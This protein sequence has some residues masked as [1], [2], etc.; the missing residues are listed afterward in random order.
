M[1]VYSINGTELSNV[2]G[3]NGAGL[4]EAFSIDDTKVFPDEP[5]VPTPR[6][7]LETAILSSMPSISVSGIKQGA[8]T[9]GTYIY[10]ICFASSSYTSGNFIK[11]KIADGTYTLYPFDGSI[12]FGHG[13]DMAYN[14]VN[15]HIYVACMTDNG[16]VHELT[17][18]FEY[19]QTHYLVG[20]SG[21]TYKVWQCFFNHDNNMFY[22]TNSK[23][24]VNGMSI[25]DQNF[26]LTDWIEMPSNLADTQ[27]GCET[28]GD[29]IYRVTYNPNR[30]QVCDIRGSGEAVAII[31][32]PHSGEPESLSYN[33][34]TGEFYLNSY[35]GP[36]FQKIQLYEEDN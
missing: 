23:N 17:N 13:N 3:V 5:P 36:L 9:D 22:S 24:G 10:Q 33:W 14:P 11:Y 4:T 8:C 7:F 29:Y 34:S 15:Q 16:A 12:N 1:P 6:E 20:Q 30:I 28:D 21:N 32:N 19:V 25:Y 26:T 18:E 27:Q 31:N 35:T 2:Y